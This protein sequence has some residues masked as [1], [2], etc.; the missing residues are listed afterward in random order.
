MCSIL[1]R[2]TPW[3]FAMG[4][5]RHESPRGAGR[6]YSA[7]KCRAHAEEKLAQAEH[8]DRNR[9]RLITAAEGWLLLASHPTTQL[10]TGLGVVPC[11]A[12]TNWGSLAGCPVWGLVKVSVGI[13]PLNYGAIGYLVCAETPGS[14]V[15]WRRCTR[16]T[17]SLF[18][19]TARNPP[20]YFL[21]AGLR[22]EESDRA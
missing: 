4:A 13:S 11:L 21:H 1:T 15:A 10:C 5:R 19:I 6:M 3:P 16:A 22:P 8:D 14:E 9:N 18:W 17:R 2:L 7:A 20:G 12:A